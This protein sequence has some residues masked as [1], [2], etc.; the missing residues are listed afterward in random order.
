[1]ICKKKKKIPPWAYLV[2]RVSFRM[3]EVKASLM[4][5]KTERRLM[6]TDALIYENNTII[7]IS[8][9][10]QDGALIVNFTAITKKA[11]DKSCWVLQAKV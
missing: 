10:N 5:S 7:N 11:W 3:L 1:M 6:H 9:S 8:C 4:Y 2:K